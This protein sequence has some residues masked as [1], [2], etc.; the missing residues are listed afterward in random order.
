MKEEIMQNQLLSEGLQV[1]VQKGT[2]TTKLGRRSRR[3]LKTDTFVTHF[4]PRGAYDE[5]Q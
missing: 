2:G 4:C 3:S 5:P 1:K